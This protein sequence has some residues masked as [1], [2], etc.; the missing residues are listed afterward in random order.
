[1]S[2]SCQIVNLNRIIFILGSDIDEDLGL[3]AGEGLANNLVDNHLNLEDDSKDVRSLFFLFNILIRT[4]N[5]RP[6]TF[7]ID[8]IFRKS[9]FGVS[10]KDAT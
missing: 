9:S 5:H 4:P 3:N 8:K 10:V 6:E 1:M 2:F 7:L